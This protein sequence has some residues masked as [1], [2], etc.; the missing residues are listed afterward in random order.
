MKV[1]VVIPTYNRNASVRRTVEMVA[2]CDRDEI[3]ALEIIVVDDGSSEPASNATDSIALPPS[4]S[5]T[6]IPKDNGGA[7][8]ARN[9]G[10][11]KATGEMILFL[12]DDMM[13]PK[14]L[15]QAHLRAHREVP[16]AVIC[17]SNQIFGP[18]PDSSL[19][20]YLKPIMGCVDAAHSPPYSKTTAASGNLSIMRADFAHR[21]SFYSDLPV[22]DD[23]E[24]TIRLKG[25]GIP[26]MN[27]A[28]IVVPTE[29][30]TDI[31]GFVPRMQRQ[32][33]GLGSLVR[34]YPNG[35]LPPEVEKMLS[36]NGPWMR[37][38]SMRRTLKKA[39][40]VVLSRFGIPHLLLAIVWLLQKANAPDRVLH[41][42]Y[43]LLLDIAYFSGFR[44]GMAKK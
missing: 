12:D 18:A 6:C 31:A 11:R 43:Q 27:A 21:D 44:A 42:G 24:L 34:I 40:L 23:P 26:I 22:G 39:A 33:Y 7:G 14:D 29:M 41:T 9:V 38:D 15:L 19:A 30:P 35:D 37:K 20:R 28:R 32:A 5:L 36:A 13:P 17:G 25:E 2:Q 16:S 8:A 4:T 10:F 1:T 3:E